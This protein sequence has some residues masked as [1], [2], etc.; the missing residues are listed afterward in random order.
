MGSALLVGPNYLTPAPYQIA[1][2]NRLIFGSFFNLFFSYFLDGFWG[3][4]LLQNCIQN[5]FKSCSFLYA[6][7]FLFLDG[8]L[9]ASRHLFS[10]FHS[11]LV[12]SALR[13]YGFCIG[14]EHFSKLVLLWV[15]GAL[16]G[17][18]GASWPNLV[19]L[20]GKWRLKEG[21]KLVKSGLGRGPKIDPK[22]YHFLDQFWAYFGV[23]KLVFFSYFFGSVGCL[24]PR[25][26]KMA[27]RRPKTAQDGPKMAPR[28]PKTAP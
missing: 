5:G 26:P 8:L 11:S 15:L 4:K 19:H 12:S 21:P 16:Q 6:L 18:L 17:F 1:I 9:M 7:L 28:V 22:I 2:K 27:P 24:V 20:G 10:Y 3:S 25:W 23:P 13:N 14:K